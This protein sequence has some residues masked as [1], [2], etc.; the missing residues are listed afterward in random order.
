MCVGL[1][2]D[3]VACHLLD[4]LADFLIDRFPVIECSDQNL[5]AD[6]VSQMACHVR[7]KAVALRVVHDIDV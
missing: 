1:S 5:L 6:A 2:A 3:F 7:H 4:P